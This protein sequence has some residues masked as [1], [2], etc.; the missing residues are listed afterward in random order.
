MPQQ[1]ECIYILTP[2]EH[3]VKCLLADFER[4]KPRYTGAHLLWTSGWFFFLR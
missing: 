2:V 3:I 1:L 4:P